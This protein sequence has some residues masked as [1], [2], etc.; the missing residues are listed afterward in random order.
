MCVYTGPEWDLGLPSKNLK[1]WGCSS[2]L[3][4]AFTVHF[5]GPY[6][7]IE[8]TKASL[9]LPLCYFCNTSPG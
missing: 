2:D 6:H 7:S 5:F 3:S 8:G 9:L 1:P 4:N